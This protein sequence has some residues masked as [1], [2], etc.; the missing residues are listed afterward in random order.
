MKKCASATE[1]RHD[2]CVVVRDAGHAGHEDDRGA[3][4]GATG[5]EVVQSSVAAFDV[6]RRDQ[7]GQP[8]N[9]PRSAQTSCDSI[10]RP[11]GCAASGSVTSH[12]T[13]APTT[14]GGAPEASNP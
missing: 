6:A 2:F 7:L 13:T 4:I 8:G 5:I 9:R 11:L 10:E 12:A 14:S 1:E 3:E